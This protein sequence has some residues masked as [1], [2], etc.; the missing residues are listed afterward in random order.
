MFWF[1]FI[2][3]AVAAVMVHPRV[4]AG[5]KRGFHN[6]AK[7]LREVIDDSNGPS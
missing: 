2:V 3:L 4:A 5:V 7:A 6:F 1:G